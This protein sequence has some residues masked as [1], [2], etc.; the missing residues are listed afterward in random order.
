MDEPINELSEI[1]QKGLKKILRDRKDIKFLLS[2]CVSCGLCSET[3]FYYKNTK[4]PQSTPSY[5]MLNSA[6]LLYKLNSNVRYDHLIRM[7]YLIWGKCVLCGRCFCPMGINIPSIIA[8]ARSICREHGICENY[9]N[10]PRG[11]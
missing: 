2:Y 11:I 6:G 5:K 1:D 10:H 4:D 8:F 9:E 7:K 3:C